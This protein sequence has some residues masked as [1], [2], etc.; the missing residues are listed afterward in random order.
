MT[1][2][3]TRVAE[4]LAEVADGTEPSDRLGTITLA[5]ARARARTRRRRRWTTGA[6]GALVA[7]STL[8]A[9]AM[10][11]DRSPDS[12]APQ[13]AAPSRPTQSASSDAPSD[14]G[15]TLVISYIGDTPEGPRL[16]RELRRTEG[17]PLEVAASAAVGRDEQGR[18][19]YPVDTD[20]RTVWPPLTAATARL[21][22]DGDLIEVSLGGDPERDLRTRGALT[23]AEA[24]LAVEALVRTVQDATDARRPVR[25]LLFG[26]RTDRVLG[27][28][29]AEPLDA[30][31]DLDVLARVSLTE[32]AENLL[33][34]NDDPLVVRGLALPGP[35]GVVVSLVPV[36]GDPPELEVTVPSTV[37]GRTQDL[38]PFE[39]PLDLLGV[40]PGD[41]DLL[42]R[43]EDSTGGTQT[44]TRTITVVD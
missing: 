31:P 34:D 25:L 26:E 18:K 3:D 23:P 29:T 4:L 2:V 41:Y 30:S 38:E 28:P 19:Q 24:R 44:D 10:T 22:D 35:D 42:A 14:E 40:A 15:T 17:D 37:G 5:T 36:S 32:P 7:A 8:V 20:Y 11:T 33:V 39:L 43:T 1:D 9:V 16:F 6:V 21:A 13:P 12:P 27:V